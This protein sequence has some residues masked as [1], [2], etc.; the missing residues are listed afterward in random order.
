MQVIADGLHHHLA[1]VQPH[2]EVHSQALRAPQFVTV[3]AQRRLHRQ[4]CIA[5][6]H[7]MILMGN[8]G[9][10]EGHNPSPITWLTVPSAVDG[11]H[12]ALQHRIQELSGFLGVARSASSSMDPFRSAKSTVT[13][14]RS[15]SRAWREVRIFSAR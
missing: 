1:G 11:G 8:W 7:G 5:G 3:A 9:A 10:K 13:C 15:P 2:P 6:P 4:R 14:L 12:H